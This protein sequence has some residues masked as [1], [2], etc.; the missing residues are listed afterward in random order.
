MRVH[1]TTLGCRLNEAELERWSRDFRARGHELARTPGEADLV[2]V[3]TCAVTDE[4]VRKSRKLVRRARRANPAAKVIVSGCYGS[5]DPERAT[6]E[7]GADVLV[8]NPEKDRLVEIV[9]RRLALPALPVTLGEPAEAA[10]FARGRQRAFVKVQDGCRH[11]CSFCVV[12]LARGDERSRPIAEIVA[13]VRAL[14]AAGVQEVVLTGVHLGG[15]GS[16]RG[17]CLR[18]LIAA[19]LDATDL[20]RLRLGSLEPWDLPAGLWDLFADGRLMPHLHLPLQSGAD[21]VLRRMARRCRTADFRALARAAR[22]AVPDLNLT[23]DL[24]V[25]FPG[26]TEAEW[27]ATLDFVAEV[28]FGHVHVFGFSPRPGTKAATLPQP[29]DAATRERRSRELQA[30]ARRLKR[31]ALE[32]LLDRHCSVLVEGE[33]GTRT[34]AGL[35]WE[36]YTAGYHR[37]AIDAPADADLANRIVDVRIDAVGPDGGH[38]VARLADGAK[39]RGNGRPRA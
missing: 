17:S 32:P 16:D 25:G 1:L 21:T 27:R 36:G 35:R 7:L 39:D 10:L 5:L 30:L 4:A 11:R 2:V 20:P 3:N 12:T 13:E 26:E 8:P 24:I 15:Y 18:A 31:E 28:G 9:S 38:L 19:V 37:V 33:R 14:H 6:S 29:V 23:T 22:S 34:G